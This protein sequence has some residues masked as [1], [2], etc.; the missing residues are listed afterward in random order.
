MATAWCLLCGPPG[1][2]WLPQQGPSSASSQALTEGCVCHTQPATA[3]RGPGFRDLPAPHHCSSGPCRT[4]VG[5]GGEG[6]ATDGISGGFWVLQTLPLRHP[7]SLIKHLHRDV[8]QALR[9]RGLRE[10]TAE[11]TC[12]K[13][14]KVCAPICSENLFCPVFL[15]HPSGSEQES[16]P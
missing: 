12:T 6:R 1:V 15:G 9:V 8:L 3:P 11:H 16:C 7:G 10:T 4:R 2:S 5:C 14:V 13:S